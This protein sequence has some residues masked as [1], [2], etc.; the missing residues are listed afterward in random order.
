AALDLL[1]TDVTLL[2]QILSDRE[3]SHIASVMAFLSNVWTDEI[4]EQW[5]EAAESRDMRALGAQ[6]WIRQISASQYRGIDCSPLL[7]RFWRALHICASDECALW[8]QILSIA[9]RLEARGRGPTFTI[10]LHNV[11]A[12]TIA[13][14]GTL[15]TYAELDQYQRTNPC[16]VA[17][18]PYAAQ[19]GDP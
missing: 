3:P 8:W 9:G 1:R 16:I 4:G 13:S 10:E 14:S 6:I 12:H 19:L 2:I 18:L 11:A 17:V 5:F 15:P 7:H